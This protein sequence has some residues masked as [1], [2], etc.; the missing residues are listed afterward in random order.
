MSNLHIDA[1]LGMGP[2]RI[3]SRNLMCLYCEFGYRKTISVE[4]FHDVFDQNCVWSRY[5]DTFPILMDKIFL[6]QLRIISAPTRESEY[7]IDPVCYLFLAI[8]SDHQ[9]KVVGWVG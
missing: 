3:G 2:F 9:V 1:A 5:L 4:C 6:R 8:A 7:R